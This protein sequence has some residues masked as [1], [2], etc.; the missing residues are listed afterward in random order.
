VLLFSW[1]VEALRL[2]DFVANFYLQ[3]FIETTFARGVYRQEA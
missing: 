1:V 3:L 2:D